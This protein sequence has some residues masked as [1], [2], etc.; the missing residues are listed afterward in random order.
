[1][2]VQGTSKTRS[3]LIAMRIS[4]A[5]GHHPAT[6]EPSYR[7]GPLIWSNFAPL[8]AAREEDETEE[9]REDDLAY[10][11]EIKGARWKATC[12]RAALDARLSSAERACAFYPNL[13]RTKTRV[14]HVGGRALGDDIVLCKERLSEAIARIGGGFLEPSG[15][16][17]G[18]HLA[19]GRRAT[20]ARAFG[21]AGAGGPRRRRPLSRI[22]AAH[23]PGPHK[24][25]TR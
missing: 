25:L 15:K 14:S 2:C 1:M 4:P 20:A 17:R 16:G 5:H 11:T 7:H 18:G 9:D 6:C 13:R 21:C 24:R 8:A 12:T 3:N 22:S 19:C 10:G 23:Y